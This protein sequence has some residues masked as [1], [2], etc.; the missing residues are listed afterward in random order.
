M[1]WRGSQVRSVEQ[2]IPVPSE[3]ATIVF[4]PLVRGDTTLDLRCPVP[5][6]GD[7]AG[8]AACNEDPSAPLSPP[9]AVSAGPGLLRAAGAVLAGIETR[10]GVSPGVNTG[11]VR[12]RV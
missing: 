9:G 4:G 3:T 5:A 8:I 2:L 6:A 12:T 11:P 1:P 7:V 10:G